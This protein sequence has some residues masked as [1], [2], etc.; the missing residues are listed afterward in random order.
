MVKGSSLFLEVV[1]FKGS[2]IPQ[3]KTRERVK[4]KDRITAGPLWKKCGIRRCDEATGMCFAKSSILNIANYDEWYISLSLSLFRARR[5]FCRSTVCFHRVQAPKPLLRSI[6]RERER[7][8]EIWPLRF[9][10]CARFQKMDSSL[11]LS[12]VLF[13]VLLTK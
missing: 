11:S 9:E 10:S 3:K 2:S 4:K 5:V 7:E 1:V 13:V 6:L 8:R 12:S